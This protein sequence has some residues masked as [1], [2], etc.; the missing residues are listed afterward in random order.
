MGTRLALIRQRRAMLQLRARAQRLE[1]IT[2]AQPWSRPLRLADSIGNI[3]NR[4]RRH[5]VMI[6]LTLVYLLSTPR[7]RLSIWAGRVLS[8]WEIVQMM[9]NGRFNRPSS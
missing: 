4:L 3:L 2:A 1:L 6:G 5:P 8:I 9:R 7:N